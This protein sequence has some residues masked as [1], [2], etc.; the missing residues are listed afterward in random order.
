[1]Y[2]HNRDACNAHL[3]N[4]PCEES[5]ICMSERLGQRRCSQRVCCYCVWYSGTDCHRG[6]L[7]TRSWCRVLT[8]DTCWALMKIVHK[9]IL[10]C[11]CSR[12]RNTFSNPV[13]L[14]SEMELFSGLIRAALYV[15][16]ITFFNWVSI[17]FQNISPQNWFINVR[18]HCTPWYHYCITEK[19]IGTWQHIKVDYLLSP[20][21][22][23]LCSKNLH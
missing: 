23:L 11:K 15:F 13:V 18:T 12:R 2:G 16:K 4:Q 10:S 8:R 21:G 14:W 19:T 6:I 22:N 7:L 5:Q 3:C 20:K 17:R 1:M 9:N